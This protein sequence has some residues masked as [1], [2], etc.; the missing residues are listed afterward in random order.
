MQHVCETCLLDGDS[1]N[2]AR[3]YTPKCG[4][5]CRDERLSSEDD[6]LLAMNGDGPP[7][8]SSSADEEG[9]ENDQDGVCYPCDSGAR[10]CRNGVRKSSSAHAK[11]SC[12]ISSKK[13]S[14]PKSRPKPKNSFSDKVV[15]AFFRFFNCYCAINPKK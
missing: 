8:E 15:P 6:R 12:G 13:R 1:T 7:N 5:R 10:V 3:R 14:M 11:L 9:D 4:Q 2:A